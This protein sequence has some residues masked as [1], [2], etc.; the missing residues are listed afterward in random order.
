MKKSDL[1]TK[2]ISFFLSRLY[3]FLAL[4]VAPFFALNEGLKYFSSG[5]KNLAI[6][7]AAPKLSEIG[8]EISYHADVQRFWQKEL[9]TLL[10]SSN[11]PETFF[12]GLNLLLQQLNFSAEIIVF[13]H[14]GNFS[15][16]NFL[17]DK[18]L[19]S[20]WKKAGKPLSK[21]LGKPNSI[22]RFREIDKLRPIFGRNF[23]THVNTVLEGFTIGRVLYKTDFSKDEY[24]YWFG[25][26]NSLMAVV[27]FKTKFLNRA[28]G[29]NFFFK[30]NKKRNFQI[31]L[32]SGSELRKGEFSPILAKAVSRNLERNPKLDFICL[33]NNIYGHCRIS[34]DRRA[35]IKI[36]LAMK[37]FDS[38][39]TTLLI[40]CTGLF[41]LLMM[42]RT[43]KIPDRI[44][45]LSL[46][47]QIM[48]LMT[49]TTGIPLMIL[50]F[51]AT[52]Y[53]NY[54]QGALVH[55]KNREMIGFIE[56]IDNSLNYEYARMNRHFYKVLHD[57]NDV[58][59]TATVSSET[60]KLSEELFKYAGSVEFRRNSRQIP[61]LMPK[62]LRPIFTEKYIENREVSTNSEKKEQPK[63][64]EDQNVTLI[65]NYHLATL[66]GR[67]PEQVRADKEMIV[68][69][70]FQKPIW[71]SIHELVKIEGAVTETAWGS[72]N[73]LAFI[74]PL[75]LLN[76][77]VFDS[78]LV[79][80]TA[81][82]TAA[83]YFNHR[84]L[85][86]IL[87]N[88]FNFR[89]FVID[90]GDVILNSGKLLIETPEIAEI[91]KKVTSFPFSEPLIIDFAGKPHIFVGLKSSRMRFYRYC[92]LFPLDIIQSQIDREATDLII[93]AIFA[94]LL[95]FFMILTL[96]L[97][98]LLPVN[99]LHQ[100]AQ[101]LCQRDSSFRLPIDGSD[102]FADMAKIFNASI[103]EFEELE[104][105]GIVQKRLLP[106]RPLQIEGFSIFGRSIPMAFMG[107]DYYDCFSIDENRFVMLLGDVAGHGVGA[108][109][110]MAMAKAGVICSE[111]IADDPAAVLSRLHQ[112]ILAIKNRM[113]R[114]VMT[115]QY[116]MVDRSINKMI[117]A[118][119][120]A[121]SPVIVDSRSQSIKIIDHPSAVLGGFKKSLFKNVELSIEP[122]QAILFYTDGM[123]E[124]RNPA[125]QELGYEG[126]YEIFLQAYDENAEKYYEK[127]SEIYQ[128][129]LDG[130]KPG[131]DLT[132]VIAVCNA[133]I[134]PASQS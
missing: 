117:Y 6:K 109:L 30:K 103:A 133:N 64:F 24:R 91:A 106:A 95:I 105:A 5:I 113:Q 4:I 127:I 68:E 108:A 25:R 130:M 72:S 114:K 39:K 3:L 60:S 53:F 12:A 54:K 87:R 93:I 78:Y 80:A 32:F 67:S 57:F 77:I 11:S 102:E 88:P 84:V 85:H 74:K 55:E 58:F 46:L 128:A 44:E 13:D 75:K 28:D 19:A 98:L 18:A 111:E 14:K 65:A 37:N 2:G 59:K 29:L 42:L 66:N 123:V 61:I 94:I 71:M 107:G 52:G 35:L 131:D 26:N 9:N 36:P 115:F 119:A 73:I 17:H 134:L 126:L 116:L 122:G 20:A 8:S 104:I 38:G 7:S 124:S 132:L 27:R 47:S 31:A 86:R 100:A 101:A 16:D 15:S 118:N 34:A 10:A 82:D 112:T 81:A 121:C 92:V 76:E 43:G 21:I 90:Q 40:I 41:I 96:Y 51:V 97:N 33:N 70:F 110:V 1:K 56:Q 79:I 63:R 22:E 69:M 120:G 23:F 48:I 62:N 129:W 49:I 89:V 125:G 83:N 45:N 50:G 99:R